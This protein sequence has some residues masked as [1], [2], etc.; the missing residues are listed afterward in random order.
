VNVEEQN[1]RSGSEIAKCQHDLACAA[2]RESQDPDQVH[3]KICQAY[4]T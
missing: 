3:G 4:Y 2:I 1:I